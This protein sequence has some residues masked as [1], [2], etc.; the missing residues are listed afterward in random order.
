ML[1][2]AE[3]VKSMMPNHKLNVNE[4]KI[5]I[6]EVISKDIMPYIIKAAKE[7]RS[8]VT[9]STLEFSSCSISDIIQRLKNL[10]YSIKREVF[11][12]LI[13]KWN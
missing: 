5:N 3:E 13:I 12:L 6:D 10:G 9:L 8:S 2:T 1:H 11:F 7:D 4:D